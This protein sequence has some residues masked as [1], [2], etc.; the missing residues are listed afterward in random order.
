MI[1]LMKNY[2]DELKT[3]KKI[4]V[5]KIVNLNEVLNKNFDQLKFKINTLDEL[6]K[7]KKLTKD[8]GKTKVIFEIS[9]K[10]NNYTFVLNDKRNVDNNLINELN[11]R[12]NIL[13]E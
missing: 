7:F 12:E 11:I 3:Q 2:S 4:N 8:S 6:I 9:D 13:S 5:K 10:D 1:T